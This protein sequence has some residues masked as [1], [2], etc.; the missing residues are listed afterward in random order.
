MGDRSFTMAAP[1]LWNLLPSEI[2]NIHKLD[3]FKQ[4]LKTNFYHLA[5]K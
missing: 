5:F 1:K 3:K 4:H 2:R